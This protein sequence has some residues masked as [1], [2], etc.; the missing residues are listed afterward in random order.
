MDQ[1]IVY[2]LRPPASAANQDTLIRCESFIEELCKELKD[3]GA[4]VAVSGELDDLVGAAA[5]DET[6]PSQVFLCF[7]HDPR[8]SEMPKGRSVL[9]NVYEYTPLDMIQPVLRAAYRNMF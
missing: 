7:G 5:R 6:R 1:I 8:A 9:A 3:S 2:I 4:L